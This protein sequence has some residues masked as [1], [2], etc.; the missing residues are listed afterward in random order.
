MANEA[1]Q[2]EQSNEEASEIA[3]AMTDRGFAFESTGGGC[4]AFTVYLERG[5]YL[6]VTD[7][8]SHVPQIWTE[9]CDLGVYVNP[10]HSEH[11]L[12]LRFPTVRALLAAIQDTHLPC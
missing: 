9:E 12:Y 8:D 5:A 1:L 7:C 11:A 2:R 10:E 6:M 4:T 3:A